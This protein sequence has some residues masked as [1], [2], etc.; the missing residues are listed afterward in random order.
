MEPNQENAPASAPFCTGC[1]ARSSP[2]HAF[3]VDCGRSFQTPVSA[4]APAYPAYAPPPPRANSGI[5]TAVWVILGGVGGILII[6]GGGF[7]LL[8]LVGLHA[9]SN[10]TPTP[11][12]IPT[13]AGPAF[14]VINPEVGASSDANLHFVNLEL[15]GTAHLA[16]MSYA[17]KSTWSKREDVPVSWLG[18]VRLHPGDPIQFTAKSDGDG[19]LNARIVDNT[20]PGHPVV[21]A[22]G[23]GSA[24]LNA[25][26]CSVN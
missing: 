25:V 4:P 24:V 3:C 22:S 8:F 14:E 17:I 20:D 9:L 26:C 6:G 5:L 18:V 19:T 7:L 10:P 12:E 23:T 21:L 13:S 2:G 15:D 1:G 16:E 11:T